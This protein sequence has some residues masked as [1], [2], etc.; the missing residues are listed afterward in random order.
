MKALS[1]LHEFAFYTELTTKARS[2]GIGTLYTLSDKELAHRILS[3]VRLT[4]GDRF[5]IFDEHYF[6]RATLAAQSGK[7]TVSFTLEESKAHTLIKPAVHWLLPLL[8]RD[9]F[10]ESLYSLVEMGVTSIYPFVSAKTGRVWLGEKERKR[11]RSI[12]I[13]AAEQSKNF[14]IPL[15]HPLTSLADCLIK[16]SSFDVSCMRLF[17]DA[18]GASLASLVSVIES[19]KSGSFIGCSGPEG[20]LTHEE[21]LL[22]LEAGFRFCALTPT[23]LRAQQAVALGLGIVRSLTK[24]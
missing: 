18:S 15:L 3:I 19:H 23:V 5:V 8:K 22:V 6:I 21:K 13:A 20:D 24:E 17:L 2:A 10:E 16:T 7:A 4:Q 14:H 11:C 1:T 9:A 12:M